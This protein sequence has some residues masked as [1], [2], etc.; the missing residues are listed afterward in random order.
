MRNRPHSD[1]D[2][3]STPKGSPQ[4]NAPKDEFAEVQELWDAL[5]R[6]AAEKEIELPTFCREL[7]IY[8]S[9]HM[10]QGVAKS[11]F[12]GLVHDGCRLEP[13]ALVVR[14][15]A[16][17]S[18]VRSFWQAMFSKSASERERKARILDKA[19]T[20]MESLYSP[21][22]MDASF[23]WPDHLG[24]PPLAVIGS[25]RLH[26]RLLR[27]F[28]AIPAE[29]GEFS[30]EDVCKYCLTAYVLQATGRNHDREVSALIAAVLD[31]SYYDETTHRM[32]RTRNYARLTKHHHKITNLLW[33]IHVVLARENVTL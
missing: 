9:N 20:Q 33:A 10:G 31:T 32:W 16:W 18:R 22:N 13:L 6:V 27:M 17:S 5:K 21:F 26:A 23:P 4:P 30:L 15:I 25:L 7:A 11:D 8:Y 28:R 19:A 24:S 2:R 1:R 29:T 12:D 14:V 3:S